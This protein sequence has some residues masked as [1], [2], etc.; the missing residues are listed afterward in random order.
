MP[1]GFPLSFDKYLK[2][3]GR[4]RN[5]VFLGLLD[6]DIGQDNGFAEIEMKDELPDGA[7]VELR[8]RFHFFV[9][10]KFFCISKFLDKSLV[11]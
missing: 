7:N 8:V 10:L 4:L 9:N 3:I 5:H 1:R 11:R 6:R 2:G